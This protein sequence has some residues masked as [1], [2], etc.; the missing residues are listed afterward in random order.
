MRTPSRITVLVIAALLALPTFALAKEQERSGR[1]SGRYS[2]KSIQS[3]GERHGGGHRERS[4]WSRGGGSRE[5][6]WARGTDTSRERSWGSRER[7]PR[8]AVSGRRGGAPRERTWSDRSGER[9][10]RTPSPGRIERRDRDLDRRISRRDVDRRYSGRER[11]SSRGYT[12]DAREQ[13]R[14]RDGGARYK[15][16]GPIIHHGGGGAYR[17]RTYYTS[18][19]YRPRYIARSAFWIGLTLG[20]YPAYG[21]RYYDPYCGIHF[22]S[23]EPYYGHCHGYGHPSAILVIDYRSHAPIATCIYDDGDW[24]VDDCARHDYAYEEDQYYDEGQSS[25]EY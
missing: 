16:S 19:F 2:G 18:H 22:G 6:G 23:L 13:V 12:R 11:G 4:N 24:V 21:Y 8:E 15:P 20:A 10:F 5:R 17:G 25:G 14:Y 7:V 9:V 1:H 3:R